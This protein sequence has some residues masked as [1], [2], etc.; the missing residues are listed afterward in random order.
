M[1]RKMLYEEPYFSREKEGSKSPTLIPKP[2]HIARVHALEKCLLFIII[3]ATPSMNSGYVL[4][5]G[6]RWKD[7]FT[8]TRPCFRCAS[9][10]GNSVTVSRSR[11]HKG[12]INVTCRTVVMLLNDSVTIAPHISMPGDKSIMQLRDAE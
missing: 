7:S 8:G 10:K 1:K 2:A 9:L 6:Q 3:L 12:I 5:I 4:L 11:R